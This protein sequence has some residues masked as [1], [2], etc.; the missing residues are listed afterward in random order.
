MDTDVYKRLRSH[1]HQ[2]PM[3][4]PRTENEVELKILQR[5]FTEEE[6]EMALCL[7][8]RPETVKAL[9]DRLGKDPEEL[10]VGVKSAV[11]P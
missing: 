8:P 2:H 11:D 6:A 3:G 9:A 4:F 1:Y 10:C 5:L 7:T